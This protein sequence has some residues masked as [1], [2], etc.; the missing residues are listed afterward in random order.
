MEKKPQTG[1]F[2]AALLLRL[3]CPGIVVLDAVPAAVPHHTAG[4]LCVGVRLGRQRDFSADFAG[5]AD[6]FGGTRLSLP[7]SVARPLGRCAAAGILLHVWGR[8]LQPDLVR[9]DDLA[10]LLRCTGAVLCKHPD[11]QSAESAVFPHRYAVLCRFGISALDGGLLLVGCLFRKPCILVRSAPDLCSAGAAARGKKG[12][13][14]MTY[15]ENIFLCMV[16]PL[17]VL[18]LIHI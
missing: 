13:G 17:L 1:V 7:K 6:R 4:L 16:S 11:R 5:H 18:S 10:V 9:L 12:G 14:T 2:F 3:L 8:S 15:I